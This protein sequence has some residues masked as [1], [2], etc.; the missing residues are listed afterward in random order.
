MLNSLQCC[1][2]ILDRQIAGGKIKVTAKYGFITVLNQSYDVCDF[3][4][5]MGKE[6]PIPA[7]KVIMNIIVLNIIMC[8]HG[9]PAFFVV[10]FL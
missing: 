5:K 1:H 8:M 3:A 10:V 7:G 2:F 6:C 9:N 4:K